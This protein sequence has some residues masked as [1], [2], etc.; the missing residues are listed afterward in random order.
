MCAKHAFQ[1]FHNNELLNDQG[2]RSKN[3]KTKNM[4]LCNVNNKLE[5]GQYIDSWYQYNID[6]S[7][8]KYRRYR[9]ILLERSLTFIIDSK[10]VNNGNV[11]PNFR[12]GLVE[13]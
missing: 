13:M 10:V 3:N 6:I 5:V 9:Y 11:F 12:F 2:T 4:Y 7:D 8:P 1:C